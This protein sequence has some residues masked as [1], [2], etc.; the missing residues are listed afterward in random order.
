MNA[1]AR[2]KAT[3]N[4]SLGQIERAAELRELIHAQTYFI[5]IY[6]NIVAD[7][8]EAGD[9]AGISYSLEKVALYTKTALSLRLDLEAIRRE[10]KSLEALAF[11]NAQR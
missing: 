11:G 8:A 5:G 4:L 6:A 1:P 9:D 3:A 10:T 2:T 7:F